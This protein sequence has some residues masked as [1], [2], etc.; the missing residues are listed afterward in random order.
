MLSVLKYIMSEREKIK[1]KKNYFIFIWHD[2]KEPSDALSWE[3]ISL[4]SV[5]WVIILMSFYH[6]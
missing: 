6:Y 2:K 3:V 1:K 4:G 5:R